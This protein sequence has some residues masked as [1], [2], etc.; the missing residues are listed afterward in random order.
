MLI[1]Q[2]KGIN[3]CSAVENKCG[4]TLAIIRRN[5]SVWSCTPLPVAT[6]ACDKESS[7]KAKY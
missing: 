1:S 4:Y 2:A 6:R 7:T 5:P 3:L